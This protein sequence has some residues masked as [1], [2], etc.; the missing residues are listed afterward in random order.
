MTSEEISFNV[1][2]H[3][4]H[5][6]PRN[7][8]WH[9]LHHFAHSPEI[10]ERLYLDPS[11]AGQEDIEIA[12]RLLASYHAMVS[13]ESKHIA[14]IDQPHSGI[15]EMVKH[16]FHGEFYRLMAEGDITGFASFMRN[17]LR[18]GLGYGLGTGPGAFKAMSVAGEA[19]EASV[20]LLLDRL[21]SLAEAIGALPHENPEQGRYGENIAISATELVDRIESTVGARIGRPPVIGEFGLFVDGQIIDPRVPD[22]VYTSWRMREIASTFGLSNFCEIGGG[23]GG[24]ALQTIRLGVPRYTIIDI[25]SV[26]MMQGWF[27][28]KALGKDAVCLYGE[29]DIGQPIV[30]L[31]Y[32]KF[33]SCDAAYDLILNRD[34]LPEIPEKQA[35]GYIAEIAR[36]NAAFLSINQESQGSTDQPG[37]SQLRV[38]EMVEKEPTLRR[39]S[40]S[41]HWTRKGYVEELFLPTK[42]LCRI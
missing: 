42:M 7:S 28:L 38:S 18:T 4:L 3:P 36:L 30:L 10:C 19:R 9:A 11:P 16:E 39:A 40:R 8:F 2:Q 25:P 17:G 24:T 37:I 26:S 14:P 12:S 34:S 35:R 13:N 22:D 21:A 1:S 29:P 5:T 23:L 6:F 20:L 32:W 27:L 15:W 31:P 33:S 41:P